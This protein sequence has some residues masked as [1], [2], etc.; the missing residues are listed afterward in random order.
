MYDNVARLQKRAGLYVT[1]HGQLCVPNDQ[2]LRERIIAESHNPA[3]RGHPG[4]C[5]TTKNVQREHEWPG[6]ITG[7]EHYVACC[8]SC[9]CNKPTSQSPG[10]LLQPR[11]L[12]EYTWQRVA[13]DFTVQLPKDKHGY[14]A[15]LT[16]TDRL[17]K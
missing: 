4:I 3:Y 7:V 12:P 15:I 1:E 10:G 2:D 11:P 14:N 8:P 5:K 17:T 6:L 9:Q 13:L 16:F